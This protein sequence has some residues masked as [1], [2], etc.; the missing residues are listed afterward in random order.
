MAFLPFLHSCSCF[1]DA[2]GFHCC[3]CETICR[4]PYWQ[5]EATTQQEWVAQCGARL[6]CGWQRVLA[7]RLSAWI[8]SNCL[9]DCGRLRLLCSATLP[10]RWR[11]RRPAGNPMGTAGQPIPPPSPLPPGGSLGQGFSQRK[12]EP[13][14]VAMLLITRRG[15]LEHCWFLV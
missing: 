6:G 7:H 5:L 4:T 14:Q 13:T 9:S 15:K 3:G 2:G 8:C 10:P 11:L 1:F 12:S